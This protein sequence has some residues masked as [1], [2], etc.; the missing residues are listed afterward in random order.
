MCV[1]GHSAVYH[2]PTPSV[3]VLPLAPALQSPPACSMVSAPASE[4]P[5][6]QQTASAPV[7]RRESQAAV[8]AHAPPSTEEVRTL[9]PGA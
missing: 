8:Q 7:T 2:S 6:P 9:P 5:G 4:A 1:A 3:P